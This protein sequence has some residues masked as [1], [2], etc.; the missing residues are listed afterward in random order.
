MISEDTIIEGRQPVFEAIKGD[1]PINKIFILEGSKGQIIKEITSAASQRGIVYEFI[2]K[3]R[4]DQFTDTQ[5]HQ[6][7]IAL[8]AAH[9]Y[10]DLDDILALARDKKED[11]FIIVLDEISDPHNL[12]SIIRTADAVGAHGIVIPKRRA[13]PLT[14]AVS[15]ASAGAIEHIPVAR[16]SN[17]P[18][19]LDILKEKGLWVFGADMGGKDIYHKANFKGPIALV[20]GSEGQGMG[21]LVKEKCDV[22]VTL[23]MYGKVSSLNAAVAAAILMYEI[24]KQR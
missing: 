21:R 16:V 15:K 9:R 19:T 24:R 4:M 1:R 14:S 17:I 23:P 22:L 13:A 5:N 8:A 12:G 2:N 7:V 18:K 10:Y 11:P 20:I 6:G 3:T